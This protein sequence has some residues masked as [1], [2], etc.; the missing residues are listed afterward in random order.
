MELT[1]FYSWPSFIL[2]YNNT[3]IYLNLPC[4][5][6]ESSRV[7]VCKA[8]QCLWIEGFIAVQSFMFESRHSDGPSPVTS[9]PQRRYNTCWCM[10]SLLSKM[11][12]FLGPLWCRQEGFCCWRGNFSHVSYRQIWPILPWLLSSTSLCPGKLCTYETCC[13]WV[14]CPISQMVEQGEEVKEAVCVWCLWERDIERL[15][16]KNYLEVPVVIWTTTVF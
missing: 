8:C 5:D 10:F 9:C 1:P 16:S 13:C 4:R 15:K 3:I 2:L 12:L 11:P 14:S 6:V 7:N